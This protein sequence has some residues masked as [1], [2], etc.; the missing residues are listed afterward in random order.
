M[1]AAAQLIWIGIPFPATC[2]GVSRIDFGCPKNRH[3]RGDGSAEA[4]HIGEF[5][6]VWSDG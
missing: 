5:E 1:T 3:R 2:L 4:N 6:T